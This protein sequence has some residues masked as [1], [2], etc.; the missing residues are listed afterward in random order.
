[1]RIILCASKICRGLCLNFWVFWGYILFLLKAVA[2]YV[3]Q[4]Y[5]CGIKHE[6]NNNKKLYH[7]QAKDNA[8]VSECT[9]ESVGLL[10][11]IH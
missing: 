9:A 4:L 7:A 2:S 6:K 1:M 10:M 8:N 3:R 11:L 5:A